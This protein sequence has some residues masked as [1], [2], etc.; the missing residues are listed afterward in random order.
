MVGRGARRVRTATRATRFSRRG[1]KRE[2]QHRRRRRRGK[3]QPRLPRR[4]PQPHGVRRGRRDVPRRGR[5]RA[6]AARGPGRGDTAGS[7]KT[8]ATQIAPLRDGRVAATP[9]RDG[10]VYVP[11]R[12]VASAR[13]GRRGRRPARRQTRDRHRARFL[14]RGS[15]RGRPRV[16][17]RVRASPGVVL[18]GR[19]LP[20]RCFRQDRA[21]ARAVR[22][23]GRV[24]PR[25]APGE[26]SGRGHRWTGVEARPGGCRGGRVRGFVRW[27]RRQRRSVAALHQGRSRRARRDD[28]SVPIGGR[29]DVR[30]Q[31]RRVREQRRGEARRRP[32]RLPRRPRLVPDGDGGRVRADQL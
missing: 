23:R 25:V 5:E 3:R 17:W 29:G 7:D 26:V 13:D 20:R 21:G 14:P 16:R 27:R 30:V 18:H 2:K 28:S 24:R 4:R 31:T 1:K 12:R 19:V 8:L 15:R 32:R 6:D 11:E 10:R 9:N 22:A